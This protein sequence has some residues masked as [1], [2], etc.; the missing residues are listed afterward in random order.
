MKDIK[1][2]IQALIQ[3]AKEFQ[4]YAFKRIHGHGATM[5]DRRLPSY[6][7]VDDNLDLA[8]Q[9]VE[10]QLNDCPQQ[11]D[12]PLAE[13]CVNCNSVIDPKTAEW[14]LCQ[15]CFSKEANRVFGDAGYMLWLM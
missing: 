10:E 11:E 4:E 15:E 8:I 1:T 2:D 12:T 14:D 7:K 9:I 5:G 3:A 13:L 6:I